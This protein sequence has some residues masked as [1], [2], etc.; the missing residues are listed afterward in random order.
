MNLIVE[1]E[2][3]PTGES[4]GCRGDPDKRMSTPREAQP[5]RA[6]DQH[7]GCVGLVGGEWEGHGRLQGCL[8]CL[9]VQVVIQFTGEDRM[10]G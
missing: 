10:Q 2:C 6:W 7:P 9:L 4:E 5:V 3:G 8:F 1:D